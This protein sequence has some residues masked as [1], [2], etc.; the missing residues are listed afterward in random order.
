MY[1]KHN[2]EH[3][4]GHTS[5]QLASGLS[6]DHSARDS[7]CSCSPSSPEGPSVPSV[8]AGRLTARD[9]KLKAGLLT[10]L[11]RIEGQVRGIKGMIEKDCYCDDVLQQLSAVQ[12]A[13]NAVG[14]MVLRN[15]IHGCVA[16]K[17]REGDTEIID[18][19]VA[20]IGRML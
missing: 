14:K 19:L 18:E 11:S 4:G 16:E 2:N 7:A 10:R 3:L 8:P 5:G 15:H 1:S 13:L 17:L 9:E 12:S 6:A 20:T